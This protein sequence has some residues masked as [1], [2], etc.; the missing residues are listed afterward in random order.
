MSK[1]NDGG[2][3]FPNVPDGAGG[4]F[5]DWDRGMTLRDWFAGQALIGLI[6]GY[7]TAYGS[8]TSAP[9]EVVNE[10][11]SYADAMIA[12]RDAKS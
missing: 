10:A 4:K 8:P 3:A 7:A 2:P 12:A 9:D 5:Y 1:I 6:Q 11:F